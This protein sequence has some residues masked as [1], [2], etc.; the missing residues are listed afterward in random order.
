MVAEVY[1][2]GNEFPLGGGDGSGHCEWIAR[3]TPGLLV[4]NDTQ[5]L[6]A[7]NRR[8]AFHIARLTGGSVRGMTTLRQSDGVGVSVHPVGVR[9]N[10]FHY[11]DFGDI[12]QSEWFFRIPGGAMGEA[13]VSECVL[14]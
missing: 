8:I 6:T 10:L 1:P 12:V 4:P 3:G 13:V 5:L 9:K 7:N 11:R 14:L 2:T